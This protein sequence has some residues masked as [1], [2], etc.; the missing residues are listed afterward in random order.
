[1][2]SKTSK[3]K[4][5]DKVEVKE[6]TIDPDFGVNI[7]G[8]SGEIEKVEVFNEGCSW[9]YRIKWDFETLSKVGESYIDNCEKENLDYEVIYLDESELNLKPASHIKQNKTFIA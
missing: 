7:G 9:C 4:H 5:G 1:M 3:Y 8:W 6:N 2:K